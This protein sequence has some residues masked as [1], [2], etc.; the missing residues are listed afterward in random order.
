M[1]NAQC[2]ILREQH[3]FFVLAIFCILLST[4]N[5]FEV[6]EM[7]SVLFVIFCCALAVGG[8]WFVGK[9]GAWG[10]SDPV[11]STG[12]RHGMDRL[13][14]TVGGRFVTREQNWKQYTLSLLVFNAIIFLVAYGILAIQQFLP[15]NPDGAGS[16]EASLIF[17]TACSFTS[18]TNL[19]HYSGESA[20][21]YFSQIFSIMWLQ[22]VTPAT[23]LCV[24]AALCRG[25]SG[26]ES[27]GNFH[28]DLMRSTFL[29]LIPLC[30]IVA[31]IL[32]LGGVIMTFDGSAQ[33]LTLEGVKQTIARGP[34]A[35]FVAIKQ[36]GTNG[37]GF[38]GV[39]STHP[40]E[41]ASFFTNMV[42]TVAL[43]IIPMA[44]VWIFGH[45]TGRM[46]DAAVIFCVMFI[47]LAVNAGCA[48]YFESAPS[49]AF[50][51]MDIDSGSNLEGKE[52]RFGQAGGSTWSVFTTASSNGSVGSMH[53]SLNPLSG[54]ISMIG[55]WLNVIYGGV[56]VGFV[57]MFLY[58]VVAVFISGMMVGRSPEYM[59]RKVETREMKFA[60]L[61]ILA[62]PL[63]I[64]GGTAVFAAGSWG[65][66]TVLNKGFHG[67]SEILYEF[68]SSAA[69][70]GSGFE[71]LADNTVPWNIA[72]GLVM[73]L[74]R[75][76]PIIL[77]LAI[78]GSLAA[79]R[80]SPETI[81]TLH[82]DTPLF[83]GV[84]LGCVLFV[85]ALLF[86]PVAVL[87]PVAEHLACVF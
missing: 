16:M 21:S 14:I 58:I 46:K 41:N 83:G 63:F 9:L 59:G 36:L 74:N 26:K 1:R 37:G 3:L 75:F 11:A 31:L 47:M 54:L 2:F 43:V 5:K 22:Y 76:I 29:L 55:M 24:L 65:T 56:G 52:L 19:Q 30:V 72:T 82:T 70:N 8:S 23:G 45:M 35:A 27:M 87:G 69:N 42:E 79:K 85:G 12:F 6:T 51:G 60:L 18:N 61:A 33:A 25:L 44:C 50:A 84:L 81:G 32:V 15:L 66:D 71:G 48:N 17:H 62:H 13:F 73:L 78:A 53:D 64:L 86:L 39:N 34:V 77:S 80:P 20:L 28:M 67:F 7:Y 38:F 10:M 40:F 57:N 49:P 4:L 68:T